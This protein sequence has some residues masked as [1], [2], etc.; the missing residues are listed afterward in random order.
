VVVVV[1]FITGDQF[2]TIPL[3]EVAGKGFIVDPEHSVV[4]ILKSGVIGVV[5]ILIVIVA[6]VAH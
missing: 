3:L 1:L 6:V 4:L 5:I 2:P